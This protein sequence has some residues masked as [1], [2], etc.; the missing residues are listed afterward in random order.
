MRRTKSVGVC[1]RRFESCTCHQCDVSRHRR[2]GGPTTCRSACCVPWAWVRVVGWLCSGPC[3]RGR[4]RPHPGGGVAPTHG[5]PV[6]DRTLSRVRRVVP[7]RT[8][9]R[10]EHPRSRLH[11]ATQ[12]STIR[13]A[14]APRNPSR[15]GPS[16]SAAAGPL[17]MHGQL[18]TRVIPGRSSGFPARAALVYLPPVLRR[19]PHSRLPVLLLLHGTPGGPEDWVQGGGLARTMDAFAAVHGGR[20]PLVVMPDING[21]RA[22]DTECVDGPAG[23]AETYLTRDVPD[24]LRAHLPVSP[25]GRRWAVA[26]A[27]EGATCSLMLGLRHSDLFSTIGFFS[28][29]ARPTVGRTDNPAATITQL[30]GGSRSSYE[31]HDP[32]WLM[33]HGSYPSLA[34]WL[35]CGTRDRRGGAAVCS[36]GGRGTKRR[37]LLGGASQSWRSSVVGVD[38]LIGTIHAVDVAPNRR[39]SMTCRRRPPTTMLGVVQRSY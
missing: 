26:G 33:R 30:F 12:V 25:P 27:S 19:A 24:Y 31:H 29:L 36:S 15:P 5:V 23:N 18:I 34:M 11:G 39:V 9:D 37:D 6:A 1:P 32:L 14:R 21:A 13:R 10:S 16:R 17:G 20:A 28:G 35:E 8:R 22:A 7:R 4:L 3:R 38:G 2:A